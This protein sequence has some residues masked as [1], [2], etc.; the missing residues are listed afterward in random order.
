MDD[1]V[2][3]FSRFESISS[4]KTFLTAKHQKVFHWKR[5]DKRSISRQKATSMKSI[6]ICWLALSALKT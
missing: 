5:V 4:K 2:Y 3:G 6:F 1:V